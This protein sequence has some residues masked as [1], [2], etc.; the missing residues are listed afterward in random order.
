[1]ERGQGDNVK[2]FYLVLKVPCRQTD[3]SVRLRE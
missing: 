1:M 2:Q 3:N